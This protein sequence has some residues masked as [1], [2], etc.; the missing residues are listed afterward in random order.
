MKLSLIKLDLQERSDAVMTVYRELSAKGTGALHANQAKH[1]HVGATKI[2]HFLN[3]ELFIIIDSNASRAFRTAWKLPFRGTTQ[4]GYS[5]HL[6]LE[7]MK[8]V[9]MDIS[10][11][12]LERFRA[13]EPGVPVTRI[14]DKLTFITGSK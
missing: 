8:L 14:Y 6:Y 7:C 4:P 9:Q 3:P 2:L 1:F 13:L 12:G 5:A 11:Y 10:T